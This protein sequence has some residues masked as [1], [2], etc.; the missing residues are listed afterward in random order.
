M[1]CQVR[2]RA[3]SNSVRLGPE[4]AGRREPPLTKGAASTGED[5]KVDPLRR[6][7]A[8]LAECDW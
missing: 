4:S 7:R 1:P 3:A 5:E 2:R 6:K 8:V